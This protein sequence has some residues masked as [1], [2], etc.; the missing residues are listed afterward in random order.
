MILGIDYGGKRIGLA[1]ADE[2]AG[3][4]FPLKTI[5]YN[6]RLWRELEAVIKSENIT[7]IVIGI[8]R[9]L[10]GTSPME[11]VVRNFMKELKGHVMIPILEEDERLSS[12]QA[13]RLKKD[14][15]GAGDE[16]AGAAAI[17]LQSYLDRQ[18]S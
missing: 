7:A 18:S 1:V 10:S 17:I 12:K 8:P 11:A 3:V 13:A 14:A 16:D 2:T 4:A 15:Q 5:E 6:E 9:S